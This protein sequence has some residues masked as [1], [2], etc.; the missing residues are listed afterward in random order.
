MNMYPSHD[1][2]LFLHHT[3]NQDL[4]NKIDP[5]YFNYNRDIAAVFTIIKEHHIKFNSIP[6]PEIISSKLLENKIDISNKLLQTILS[7]ETYDDTD[8][9]Y[10]KE[11]YRNWLAAQMTKNQI[12]RMID[13]SNEGRISPPWINN[14]N[15]GQDK[16]PDWI[17][18][19]S[20]LKAAV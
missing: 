12:S 14:S 15:G 16:A 20:S 1:L 9:T 11:Q 13:D 2:K 6:R 19:I 3:L 7:P 17:H 5:A 10:V 8:K 18:K 4:I